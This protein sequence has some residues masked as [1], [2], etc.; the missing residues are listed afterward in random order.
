MSGKSVRLK[1]WLFDGMAQPFSP[2]SRLDKESFFHR[3]SKTT[4]KASLRQRISRFYQ[5]ME[6]HL[7][8]R[9]VLR[10]LVVFLSRGNGI[11]SLINYG[12]LL[13]HRL[14][15]VSFIH[16]DLGTIH[17]TTESWKARRMSWRLSRRNWLFENWFSFIDSSLGV[18]IGKLGMHT[19]SWSW[20]YIQKRQQHK[21][22]QTRNR[23]NAQLS[24]RFVYFAGMN[25]LLHNSNA[26]KWFVFRNTSID[27]ELKRFHQRCWWTSSYTPTT[28]RPITDIS[29]TPELRWNCCACIC[30]SAATNVFPA[31]VWCNWRVGNFMVWQQTISSFCHFDEGRSV[32][33]T[34]ETHT[35]TAASFWR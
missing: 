11:L 24:F 21:Q 35:A 19:S 2:F 13:S 22:H 10:R 7:S 25:R 17:K 30:Y 3:L 23:A 1:Q 4:S 9:R 32:A 18:Q 12:C 28:E 34:D 27:T 14:H 16:L 6:P 31:F 26:R 5:R 33:A 29:W 15:Q 8:I 20:N